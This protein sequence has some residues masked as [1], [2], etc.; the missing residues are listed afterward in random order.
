M[1]LFEVAIVQHPT[2]K[3]KEEGHVLETIVMSPKLV[4]AK[5]GNGAAIAAVTGKD[6]PK[7]LDMERCEVLIR[8]FK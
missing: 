8:P 6:A 5:D 1:P 4:V 3:Q 7:E 2:P